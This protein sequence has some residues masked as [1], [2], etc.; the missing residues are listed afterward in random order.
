[1]SLAD[2]PLNKRHDFNAALSSSFDPG[3]VAG[4]CDEAIELLTRIRGGDMRRIASLSPFEFAG[5]NEALAN[6][7]ESAIN[8]T[9]LHRLITPKEPL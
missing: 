2:V 4:R 8:V 9:E 6:V 7:I 1:M 3:V 5:L